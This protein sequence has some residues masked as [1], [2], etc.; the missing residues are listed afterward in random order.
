LS[1][2]AAQVYIQGLL[3]GLAMPG[4]APDL[5]AYITPP[6]V[7]TNPDATPRA[8]VWPASGNESR[9]PALGGTVPRASTL[10]GPSGTK[11]VV[12]TLH[13]YVIWDQANDDPQA[14][15]WFPGMLEAI[16]ST[17]R[18]SQ[19]PVQV[20]DPYTSISSWLVDVGER[21]SYQIQVSAL[22]SQRYYRYDGLISCVLN[23]LIAS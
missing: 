20:T 12:H 3:N 11:P 1:I 23:E 21:M 19:D 22:E 15:T 6:A 10:G 7:D 5:V 13:I 17:L 4:S 14:D 16:M 9:N 18:V 8:Y 2:N